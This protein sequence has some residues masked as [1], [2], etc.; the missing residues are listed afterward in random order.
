MEKHLNLMFIGTGSDTGKSLF[1]TAFCRILK[2]R[3]VRVAPFKAQNMALNS[4]V[5]MDGKEMGR[6]QVIQAYAAGLQPESD[7]NP[8]LLKPSGGYSIQ[9]IVN[10]EVLKT[11]SALNYYNMIDEIKKIVFESYRRLSRKYEMIILEGAGSAVELNLKKRD[12]VNLP[13][14]RMVDSPAILIGDIDRGGIFASIIGSIYLMNNREKRLV[15]GS[16]INRFRGNK[17][18]FSEGVKIIEKKTKRPVFGV[19]P[20]LKNLNIPEEDIVPLMKGTKGKIKCKASIKI[21]VVKLPFISNYTDFDPFEIENDVSLVYFDSPG[22][23]DYFDIII[24]PG[25]KSTIPDMLWMKRMGLDVAIRNAVK[26]GKMVMGICGGFQM[27]GNRIE[28]PRHI[29]SP[30]DSIDGIGLISMKTVL[31]DKKMLTR[32]KA[33][34]QLDGINGGV[35]EGY[36]IHMGKSYIERELPPVFK[37]IEKNGVK[38]TF[39]DG[40]Q[41][42]GGMIWGTYI[43]GIFENDSF[44]AAIL[45][46]FG[47]KTNFKYKAYVETQFD[48]LADAVEE[49]IDVQNIFKL[50]SKRKKIKIPENL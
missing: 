20:Y 14:A 30:Y 19:M 28:D 3:G 26:K 47:L 31:T 17:E 9:I 8:V 37:I 1:T 22:D 45:G 36:E 12:I 38:T 5:T 32:V 29:E 25:T 24:I 33:V 39:Y 50:L 44:R 43:H 40:V 11:D 10:G 21:G 7:M 35:I 4:F 49:N 23:I 6:A 34:S 15:I 27:M 2:R 18:L 16:I 46:K 42:G 13:M 41:I 48:M